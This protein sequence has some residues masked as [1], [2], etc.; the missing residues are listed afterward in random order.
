MDWNADEIAF[1]KQNGRLPPSIV[2]HHINSVVPYGDWQGDPR[3]IMFVRGQGA[4]FQA[5]GRDF[6]TPTTGPL[7]DRQTLIDQAT[8]AEPR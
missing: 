8:K 3:N 2:G 5:H 4:N 7:I 1:I 6:R